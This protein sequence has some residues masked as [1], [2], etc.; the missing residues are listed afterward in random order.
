[1][2]LD[3]NVSKVKNWH[4]VCEVHS[5]DDPPGTCKWSPVTEALVWLCMAC[6]VDRITEENWR[7]VSTR[8]LAW[9]RALGPMRY[10]GGPSEPPLLITVADVKAHAGLSTN[11]TRKSWADYARDLGQAILEEAARVARKQGDML[12][13]EGAPPELQSAWE[14]HPAAHRR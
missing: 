1:M 5:P 10:S 4:E 11:V 14:K 7:E 12:A 8:F 2:S 3:W 9:E 13:G 6:G